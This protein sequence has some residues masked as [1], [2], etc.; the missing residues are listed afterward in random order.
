[1]MLTYVVCRNEDPPGVTLS[2]EF[3]SNIFPSRPTSLILLVTVDRQ[4]PTKPEAVI[5]IVV[6]ATFQ[7]KPLLLP[8]KW[9]DVIFVVLVLFSSK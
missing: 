7:G 8:C 4:T 9:E 2:F 3:W 1:M 6:S 5:A